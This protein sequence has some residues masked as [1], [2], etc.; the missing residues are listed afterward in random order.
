MGR[1]KRDKNGDIWRGTIYLNASRSPQ[2]RK[3]K[4]MLEAWQDE[5]VLT[6]KLIELCTGYQEPKAQSAAGLEDLL[7]QHSQHII[8]TLLA[9]L[10]GMGVNLAPAAKQS[11][12]Q[13]KDAGNTD[14]GMMKYISSALS[15]YDDLEG[16][17]DSD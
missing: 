15:T 12:K 4:E 13:E 10:N 5:N 2:E 1:R 8:S 6:K 9:H 17:I 16:E 14:R 3:A 7:E 11:K